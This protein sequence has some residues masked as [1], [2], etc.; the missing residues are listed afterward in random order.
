MDP[1]DDLVYSKRLRK[2][3]GE[4]TLFKDSA[5][6]IRLPA[7]PLNSSL[8]TAKDILTVQG[9]T[10]LCG[11]GMKKS[12]RKHDNDP[13]FAVKT[14]LTLFGISYDQ[15]FIDKVIEES[16]FIIRTLK[17][18]FNR[19]RPKQLAPYFGVDFKVLSSRSNKTPSYPSGHSTQARLIAEIYA[20][21]H[22]EHRLNLIKAA[23]ECGG[24]RVMAG[25]H[26]PTDHKAGVYL[27]KRLFKS[28]KVKNAIT[29]DL[30]ID[31]TTKGEK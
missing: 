9:A 26:Y 6:F 4:L 12:V 24:G 14:Y 19:P 21:K 31:L 7:P 25:F 3:K 2:P 16:S 23:E 15:E 11:E 1:V 18:S 13:A 20:D 10:F 28:L 5:K 8:D 27:A 30:K 17:N 22:P 29:Y